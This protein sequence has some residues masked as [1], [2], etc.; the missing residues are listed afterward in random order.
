M[1]SVERCAELSIEGIARGRRE[2][3]YEWLPLLLMP[4][5]GFHAAT[6]VLDGLVRRKANG[7]VQY[8]K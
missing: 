5:E 1:Q 4:L 8:E 2:H 7:G 3:R 6:G